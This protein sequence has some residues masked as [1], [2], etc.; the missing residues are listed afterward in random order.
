MNTIKDFKNDLLKR[1]EVKLVVD[2]DR[3]PGLE[4]AVKMIAEH[5]KSKEDVIVVKTLKSKFGRDTFLIDAFIYNSAA[6]KDKFEPKKKEKK[7][8]G[9]AA[10]PA[11]GGNK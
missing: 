11:A 5:F 6:D 3:N 8:E 10:Q 2:S 1:R 7:K 4:N 9:E